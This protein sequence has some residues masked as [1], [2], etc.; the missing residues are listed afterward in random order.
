MEAGATIQRLLLLAKDRETDKLV[1]HVEHVLALARRVQAAGSDSDQAISA[2]ATT[3]TLAAG[4]KGAQPDWRIDKATGVNGCTALKALLRDLE[5]LRSREVAAL[6][7]ALAL[8]VLESLRRVVLDYAAERKREGRAEFHDLLFWARDLLRGSP[9]ARAHFQMKF[10]HILI[11]ESQDTDPI[12]AEIAFFL[13]GN[14]G[15]SLS[16]TTENWKNMAVVPGKLFVV[17]DPK[18]SIYRFRRADIAIM[19]EVRGRLQETLEL[20]LNHRSQA[21]ILTWVNHV[22]GQW[23]G[24]GS[25]PLQ[26]RY[27]S[28]E[29]RPS[30]PSVT[31][32][33]GVSWIGGPIKA[34]ADGVRKAESQELAGL[35]KAIR[36]GQWRVRDEEREGEVRPASYRDV[37]VLI[38][39]RTGL[40]E[41]EQALDDA[42]LPYRVESQSLVLNTQ[43]VREL[44]AC[45]RAIDSPAD[46]VAVAAALRSSAF[47]CSDVDLLQFVE[48]GGRFDYFRP[49]GATGLVRDG[50][51]ALLGYHRLRTW[52]H[53]DELIERF[54]RERRMVEASFGRQRPRE[55]WRRLRFVVERA[56]AY[57]Q[58]E[59]ST[60]RG[61]LDWMERQAEEGARMI[62]VPVPETDEDAVRIMT[63]HA[64]K[65]LQ[66]PIVVLAGIGARPVS[67]TRQVIFDRATGAVEVRVGGDDAK[68]ATSG[69]EGAQA[70]EKEAQMA[71]AVRLM[72]VAATRARDHLLVSLYH[73]DGNGS[74]A[75]RIRRA[76]ESRSDLWAP[77]PPSLMGLDLDS[78]VTATPVPT[79]EEV[80]RQREE[81]QQRRTAIVKGASV[82]AALAAT[83]L[84]RVDKEEAER[85]EAPHRRGRGGTNV[86]RAV[87]GV[88]QTIDLDT[89]AG[90]DE[91]ARAQAAAEGI[92]DRWPDVARLSRTALGMEPVRR[93][94]ASGRYYREVFVGA[95]VDGALLE[96]FI[97]LLFEEDGGLVIV[98]YKTD[99]VAA[100]EVEDAK[101]RYEVQAGV[102]ALAA[103]R[104][105]G[106]PVREALLLFLEPA[107]VAAFPDVDA[108]IE[109]ARGRVKEAVAT[110]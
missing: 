95:P 65:G 38:P 54:I 13:A 103:Q 40:R 27:I 106:K 55:R 47:A 9:E 105:T 10:S 84:A 50:L 1:P 73:Q 17:G 89:G 62:E 18:Q 52:V 100:G 25:P 48:A 63:I 76:C 83:D 86:G 99:A 45:L 70:K 35:L 34:S 53:P 78:P 5:E 81:W 58:A 88:L 61:F 29:P 41:L 6:R 42:N 2:L 14:P 16:R 15:D 12:Q 36:A 98:D 33:H 67:R 60:L 4:K 46:Q 49:G 66:F 74:H 59:G 8:P 107:L 79:A 82:K 3:R 28:L 20:S 96:G 92:P 90:L 85:G 108:L 68:F 19:E 72:Y 39:A 102:Y 37:C 64:S 71:E 7:E 75:A 21:N 44:V 31:P 23:M 87:H 104:I 32:G 51:D 43:D 94:V 93:A 110:G 24:E 26:A 22:F 56:R 77:A 57:A 80:Q 11:D 97:D 109:K 101:Q 69:Y 91:T 30:M